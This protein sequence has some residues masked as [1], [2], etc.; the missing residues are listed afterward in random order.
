M[1]R[2]SFLAHTQKKPSS[3]TNVLSLEYLVWDS[4]TLEE[5][6]SCRQESKIS[7]CFISRFLPSGSLPGCA[8]RSVAGLGRRS[9]HPVRLQQGLGRPCSHFPI[10]SQAGAP[11]GGCS[12]STPASLARGQPEAPEAVLELGAKGRGG[13]AG[14]GGWRG[15]E[16]GGGGKGGLGSSAF[17]PAD[18]HPAPFPVRL[19]ASPK[20]PGCHINPYLAPLKSPP[21]FQEHLS[22]TL[23]I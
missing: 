8:A 6:G 3:I 19:P 17:H 11:Q 16:E 7:R 18:R 12:R 21:S 20:S 9:E 2:S 10:P 13:E 23:S 4:V 22:D 1:V 15:A 14:V 5:H